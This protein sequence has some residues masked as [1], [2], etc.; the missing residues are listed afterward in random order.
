MLS[1][2]TQGQGSPFGCSVGLE[3]LLQDCVEARGL[4]ITPLHPLW[5]L[6]CGL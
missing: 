3:Q 6:T 2:E 1:Q 5:L 4:L